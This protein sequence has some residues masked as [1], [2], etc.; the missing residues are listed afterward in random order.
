[1]EIEK[2]KEYIGKQA[3]YMNVEGKIE[4]VRQLDGKMVLVYFGGAVMNIEVVAI[5][6]EES[7]K[8]KTIA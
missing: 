7:G 1:M 3:R 2:A 4:S 8:W 6:D 5:K